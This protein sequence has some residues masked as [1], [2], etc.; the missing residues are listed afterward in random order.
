MPMPGVR[1]G[2]RPKQIEIGVS[3]HDQGLETV[4][5]S[6]HSGLSRLPE[7]V[8]RIGCAIRI[9]APLSRDRGDRGSSGTSRL[10]TSGFGRPH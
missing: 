3:L 8:R 4:S 2:S 7:G 5:F 9:G 6:A 10:S 1:V